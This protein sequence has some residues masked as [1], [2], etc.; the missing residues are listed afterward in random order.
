MFLQIIQLKE[1]DMS[2]LITICILMFSIMVHETG[3]FVTG[4]IFNYAIEEYSI[5][6]GPKIFNKNKNG[7]R[8][9]LRILPIGGYVSF[10]PESK[11]KR[12]IS[13]PSLSKFLVLIMGATFNLIFCIL[14]ITI[15]HCMHGYNIIDSLFSSINAIIITIKD[16][17]PALGNIDNYG[18]V[19][20]IADIISKNTINTEF[21]LS[22][23]ASLNLSVAIIN[24]LPIPITDGGKI[25]INVIELITKKKIPTNIMNVINMVTSMILIAFMVFLIFRDIGNL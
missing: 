19:I 1:V 20:S 10:S 7:I 12:C 22:I 11:D 17:L 15:I 6:F 14:L 21:L 16:F 18:S 2:S 25:V 4:K 9:T 8:Y 3:H 23:T 5:G 13:E 24:L